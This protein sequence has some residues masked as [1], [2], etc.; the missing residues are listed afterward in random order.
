MSSSCHA[1][2]MDSSDS[3]SPFVSIIHRFRWDFSTTSCV[4]TE[5]LLICSCWSFTTCLSVEMDLLEL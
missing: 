4:H 1:A 2:S 5:L 3:L